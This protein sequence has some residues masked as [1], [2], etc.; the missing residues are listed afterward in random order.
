MSL[1]TPPASPRRHPSGAPTESERNPGSSLAIEVHSL[2]EPGANVVIDVED[3]SASGEVTD[4][5]LVRDDR[6]REAFRRIVADATRRAGVKTAAD[7]LADADPETLAD[8][9]D[10]HTSAQDSGPATPSLGAVT[11]DAERDAGLGIIPG[12]TGEPYTPIS[13]R[14]RPT[15]VQAAKCL[16]SVLVCGG[17]AVAGMA[18]AERWTVDRHA[19]EFCAAAPISVSKDQEATFA[20]LAQGIPDEKALYAPFE[21]GVTAYAPT[22]ETIDPEVDRAR[23]AVR[24]AH[25]AVLDTQ[26][27]MT[28]TARLA[29]LEADL[30]AAEADFAA[31]CTDTP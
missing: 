5:R 9:D 21:A 22:T 23:A 31:A 12:V 24:R 29:T 13:G 11:L 28:D 6:A 16:V 4:P 19:A 20:A 30:K 27:T 15:A 26:G 1:T 8:L 17:V 7:W 14:R 25:Q 18:A 3:L 10:S 2:H